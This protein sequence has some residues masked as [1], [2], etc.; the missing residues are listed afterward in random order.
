[1]AR[2]ASGIYS[3]S[4]F[5]ELQLLRGIKPRLWMATI[6]LAALAYPWVVS[7]G[8]QTIGV[9]S[10][11]AAIGALGLHLLTGLAGQLSLGHA[12]F[13]GIGAFSATWLGVDRGLPAVVWIPGAGIVAAA[14]G[15]LV[16]P[17][18]TRL[19]GLYLS[20]LT[21]AL[22]FL[23]LFVFEIWPSITG[24]TNGRLA[25]AFTVNGRD[26]LRGVTLPIVGIELTGDQAFWYVCLAVLA[27]LAVAARNIQRSRMGRAFVASRERDLTAAVAGV[28]VVRTKTAAF[29]VSSFYGGVAGALLASYQSYVAP[30][31]WNLHLS[32]Q[33]V[34][35]VIIGGLGS[36]SGAI[37]G[38]FFVTCLPQLVNLLTPVL[39]FV[40]SRTTSTSGGITAELL[41]N[42]LYGVAVVAVLVWEPRGL[43]GLWERFKSIWR[44]WP[45]SY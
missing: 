15:G 14:V 3:R 16:G 31:Q 35:M 30:G 12:A 36:V 24:G 38:A 6:V 32:I 1:M 20:V 33:F 10:L 28:P 40:A 26:L 43:I 25:V 8:W 39:P 9:F 19:R 7:R 34:A 23:T 45:W 22:V 13:V 21:L 27:V 5:D 42:L 4:Y 17:I 29:V 37:L 44:T 41:A 18:A 11:I 2:V